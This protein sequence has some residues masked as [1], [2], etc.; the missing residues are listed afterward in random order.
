[1]EAN[2][3]NAKTGTG[4]GTGVKLASHHCDSNPVSGRR[5][6]AFHLSLGAVPLTGTATINIYGHCSGSGALIDQLVISSTGSV[7]N[8]AGAEM[9]V[10]AGWDSKDIHALILRSSPYGMVNAEVMSSTLVDSGAVAVPVT[11]SV[12]FR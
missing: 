12:V 6:V 7:L 10:G 3:L 9:K 2:I 1:M 8:S 11:L 4:E 5:C